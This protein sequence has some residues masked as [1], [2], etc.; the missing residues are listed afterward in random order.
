[1]VVLSS[2]ETGSGAL[3]T[4]EGIMSLSRSLLLAGAASVVHT[5][6][7]A[8]DLKVQQIMTRFYQEL[9]NGKSKAAALSVA[10]RHYLAQ[11]SPTF[12]HPYYWA[13]YQITG[14][15]DPLV[16]NRSFLIYP[17]MVLMIALAG[18]FFSRRI[19]FSRASD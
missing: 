1:M 19:F 17:L 2:C 12:A 9:K 14:N 5:M 18:Y 3:Q 7:P 4:G 13:S 16:I 11:S 6:W 8:E 15:P 10:K